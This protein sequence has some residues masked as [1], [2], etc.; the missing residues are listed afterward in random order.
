MADPASDPKKD[1][2][3]EALL[4][5]HGKDISGL[6]EKLAKCYSE[7]RYEFFESAVEKITLTIIDGS[8]RTKIK[9]HAKEAAGEYSRENGWTKLT[10]WLPWA[11]SAASLVVAIIAIFH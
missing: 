8:G 6:N 10:F 4:N 9:A 2:N 3:A 1:F 11:I 7:E 5:E